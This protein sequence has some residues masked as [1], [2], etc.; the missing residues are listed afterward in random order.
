MKTQANILIIGATGKVGGMALNYLV[1]NTNHNVIAAV[2]KKE[3]A[4]AFDTL[5]VQSVYLDLDD[6]SSIRQGLKDINRVL[7][8]T[9]YSVDML[10]QSMRVIDEAKSAGVKH[11]V[12][13]GASGNPTAEVAHWGWHRMIEAY[14]EKQGFSFTHLQP[15]AFMQNITAFGWLS[16]SSLTNLIGNSVWSW[17]DA[18][19]VGAFAGAVLAKP[20]I[21]SGQTWRLGYAR[22][23]M[24]KVARMI[25]SSV[26]Q[27]IKVHEQ[28]PDNFYQIAIENGADPAYMSC[29]RD[30]FKLNSKN[31]IEHA[32][33]IFDEHA[34]EQTVGYKPTSW[35]AFIE[36]ELGGLKAA[37][38][39]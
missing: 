31:A 16:Q 36:R 21:Y 3:Q 32:D 35:P 28:N 11:I 7:L 9:A 25:S 34:F 17:V 4:S 30:Q 20:E 10:K 37:T 38:A 5:G 13:V 6:V 18:N 12:H 1:E 33:M 19:D 14:I 26:L 27:D 2:R 23:S 39:A 8:L 22:A 15:E 29:V 24:Q